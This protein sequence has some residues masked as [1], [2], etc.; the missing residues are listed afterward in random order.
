MQQTTLFI[1]GFYMVTYICVC[2]ILYLHN[3]YLQYQRALMVISD[4]PFY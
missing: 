1:I 2:I 4:F 3:S